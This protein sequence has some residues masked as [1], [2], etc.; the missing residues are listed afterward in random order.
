MGIAIGPIGGASVMV[1]A[2][3]GHAAGL[4]PD[5][6]ATPDITSFLC[7]DATYRV[8]A[9]TGPVPAPFGPFRINM[10][11]D[12]RY[13][14]SLIA[15][16][17][18]H[19]NGP[20]I[21]QAIDDLKAAM[22]GAGPGLPRRGTIFIPANLQPYYVATT[23]ELDASYIDI[24]GEGWLTALAAK[25]GSGIEI[26]RVGFP[27]TGNDPVSGA[28]LAVTAAFRPSLTGILDGTQG[29]GR[30]GF[31][32]NGVASLSSFA[33][34]LTL[35]RSSVAYGAGTA[36]N[37][38]ETQ[39]LTVD[40][41]FGNNAANDIPGGLTITGAG[42]ISGI[43][44]PFVLFS[45]G[46]NQFELT[47]NLRATKYGGVPRTIVGPF[48]IS[49][50]PWHDLTVMIDSLAGD[51]HIFD[52][53]T[54]VYAGS[55]TP[56]TFLAANETY[57]WL[58][59]DTGIHSVLWGAPNG[60]DYTIGGFKLSIGPLYNKVA[61]GQPQV[62]FD[63]G[64]LNSLTRYFPPASGP[65][66]DANL[67]C[68]FPFTEPQDS[69]T[70][71]LTLAPGPKAAGISSQATICHA[72]LNNIMG[73]NGGNCLVQDIAFYGASLYGIN[74]SLGAPLYFTASNIYSDKSAYG[75]GG[76]P[77]STGYIH[78]FDD[79][80][81]SASESPFL[82]F[83][84]TGEVNRL[85]VLN[86]GRL[87]VRYVGSIMDTDGLNFAFTGGNTEYAFANDAG[88]FGGICRVKR[89]VLDTEG[90]GLALGVIRL[91]PSPN[92]FLTSCTFEDIAPQNI[93]PVPIFDV[94]GLGGN[95]G[96]IALEINQL[97]CTS[98]GSAIVSTDTDQLR[99]NVRNYNCGA[100]PNFI[101]RTA[102]L[103]T[104]LVFH[105]TSYSAPP[106]ATL[107]WTPETHIEVGNPADGEY[108]EFRCVAPGTP[109]TWVG[110]GLL[111]ATP[112][113]IGCHI[114]GVALGTGTAFYL[115]LLLDAAEV[116]TGTGY[117]R[118]LVSNTSGTT[119]TNKD[120]SKYI[121]ADAVWPTL[122]GPITANR[123]GVYTVSSGGLVG[124]T[125]PINGTEA[126]G[127]RTFATGTAPK[128]AA[129]AFVNS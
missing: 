121:G 86:T 20:I 36:D 97:Q 26:L 93:G 116:A 114:H 71:Q 105:E 11:Q 43:S 72:L 122:S 107:A 34:A 112:A 127:S 113:S 111:T 84:V 29:G 13:A 60:L 75:I 49:S 79:C 57:P 62:R 44:C 88:N 42:D 59:F 41:G 3:T 50:A 22:S 21:Q 124:S 100:T 81:L 38:S 27:R 77:V 2:G 101:Q 46:T 14:A 47:L 115:G 23:I 32:T 103:K 74:L 117:A 80:V 5:P 65:G 28:N 48:S 30:F 92:S 17:P 15:G 56:N 4:A 106:P 126:G 109:G 128:I 25:P 87:G 69:G 61:Q 54:C 33:S 39:K 83:F 102:G 85:Q 119:R 108:S 98:P 89:F 76:Q 31:R 118:V 120:G 8:P 24:V 18:G 45:T 6:G 125:A 40:F 90:N 63:S 95:S 78:R 10:G 73:S 12:P 35:G 91:Q 9:G 129:G 52:N 1:G 99:G 64:P 96:Q 67:L 110:I 82:T 123:V 7:R 104:Q 66:S 19:D 70:R 16:N 51:I 94:Q 58:W 37:W 68:Y 53:G 55:L